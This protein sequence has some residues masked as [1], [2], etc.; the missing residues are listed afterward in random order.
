MK[1][2]NQS[3]LLLLSYTAFLFF[4]C[5][6]PKEESATASTTADAFDR[7]VLPIKP[8]VI[9]AYTEE[10]ARNTKAPAPWEIKA[11]KG[12]PNVI[13]VLVD[14]FGFGRVGIDGHCSTSK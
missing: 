4:G 3:F 13:L 5:N 7:T 9:D 14:D 12:A 8:P 10:D 1:K 11:P 2:Y 6:Q